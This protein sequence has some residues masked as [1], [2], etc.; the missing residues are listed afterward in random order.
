MILSSTGLLQSMV[1]VMALA[2]FAAA[3]GFFTTVTAIF[4][5]CLKTKK[6]VQGQERTGH[7]A[8]LPLWP[9]RS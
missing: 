7:S 3:L 9:F 6:A 4:T 8:A 2:F 1:K 5:N